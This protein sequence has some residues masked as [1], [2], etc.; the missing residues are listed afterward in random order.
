MTLRLITA[1]LVLGLACG[2]F[3]NFVF[4]VTNGELPPT[5]LAVIPFIGG[6]WSAAWADRSQRP[7]IQIVL[8]VAWYLTILD[9]S[10]EHW[11]HLL[12]GQS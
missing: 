9:M 11:A 3:V 6:A 10:V 12:R 5:H 7:V 2:I 1:P 8:F 4:L